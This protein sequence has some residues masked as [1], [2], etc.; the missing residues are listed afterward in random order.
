MITIAFIDAQNLKKAVEAIGRKIDFKR[1][2]LYLER[3]HKIDR[4]IM[5]FGWLPKHADHYRHLEKCG[6]ELVHREVDYDY[7]V[8][9]ANVDICLTIHA[10]DMLPHYNRAYLI[11]SDG[12]FFDLTERWKLDGK[13]AGVISPS[14]SAKCSKLLRK[15]A[16]GNISFIPELIAKFE[17]RT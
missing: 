11:S 10:M 15:S 8:L 13:F 12:D 17:D 6:F 7:G 1:F 9:K 16:D 14:A 2:R 5:F 4:A 3:K